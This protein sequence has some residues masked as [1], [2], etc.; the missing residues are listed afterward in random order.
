MFNFLRKN[1]LSIIL[2]T[3]VFLVLR[4]LYLHPFFWHERLW[5]IVVLT[6]FPILMCLVLRSFNKKMILILAAPFVFYLQILLL[7]FVSNIALNSGGHL[8]FMGLP[9]F[10]FYF[11]SFN[12]PFPRNK[13]SLYV[14]FFII[15]TLS[16]PIL[17]EAIFLNDRHNIEG[18]QGEIVYETSWGT[19]R[20]S[21]VTLSSIN[22]ITRKIL[23]QS[24]DIQSI[25]PIFISNHIEFIALSPEGWAKFT[26]FEDTASQYKKEKFDYGKSDNEDFFDKNQQY[27]VISG[28]IPNLKYKSG[29]LYFL[30]G[31]WWKPIYIQYD[32]DSP[33]ILGVEEIKLACDNKIVVFSTHGA[34]IYLADLR[35]TKPKLVLIGKGQK[36]DIRNVTCD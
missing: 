5:G 24:K 8:A 1:Y 17:R 28:R 30:S 9:L 11:F 6:L 34:E 18:L 7:S 10:F 13:I 32:V 23:F 20:N 29:S 19:D 36:F 16:Y 15:Y 25:S 31:H 3:Y 4:D 27:D 22:G 12:I 26:I 21:F 33:I 14:V 2:I 35:G